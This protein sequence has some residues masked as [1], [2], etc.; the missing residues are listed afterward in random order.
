LEFR[1][2]DDPALDV[3]KAVTSTTMMMIE[4]TMAMNNPMEIELSGFIR[5]SYDFLFERNVRDKPPLQ[6]KLESILNVVG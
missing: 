5:V 6:H 4:K 3:I 1:R 2:R